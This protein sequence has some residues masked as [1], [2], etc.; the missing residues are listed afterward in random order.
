MSKRQERVVPAQGRLI[1]SVGVDVPLYPAGEVFG[2]CVCGSWP[3]G[4]CLHC[5][6]IACATSTP[7]HPF[8]A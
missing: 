3:G 6:V 7:E 2:P 5:R 8:R 1:D 4:G